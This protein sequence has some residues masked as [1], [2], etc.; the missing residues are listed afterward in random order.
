MHSLDNQNRNFEENG[1][2]FLKFTERNNDKGYW[3][4]VA[5]SPGKED[6]ENVHL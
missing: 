2:E 3:T 4:V 1:R 5:P 6:G